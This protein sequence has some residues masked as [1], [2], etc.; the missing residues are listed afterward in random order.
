MDEW[1]TIEQAA[2]YF[3]VSQ[4]HI[5]EHIIKGWLDSYRYGYPLRLKSSE[6]DAFI[7]P[8]EDI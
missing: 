5:R 7:L 1:M 6:P 3:G 2:V 8:F 4:A